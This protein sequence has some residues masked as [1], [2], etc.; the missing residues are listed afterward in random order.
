VCPS[1]LRTGRRWTGAPLLVLALALAGSAARAAPGTGPPTG[2]ERVADLGT[3]TTDE[4]EE[5]ARRR[6][7]VEAR[8]AEFGRRLLEPCADVRTAV[9]NALLSVDRVGA[10]DPG[11]ALLTSHPPQLRVRYVVTLASGRL[12]QDQVV[13]VV[14]VVARVVPAG[15]VAGGVPARR[16]GRGAPSG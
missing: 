5:V 15:T 4:R 2:S 3:L 7:A 14:P 8:L 9:R 1:R 12:V 16:C 10:V 11:P 6:M 13:M